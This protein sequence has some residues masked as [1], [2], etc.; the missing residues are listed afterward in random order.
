MCG[1]LG[2]RGQA[3]SFSARWPPVAPGYGKATN[4]RLTPRDTHLAAAAL[5][6]ARGL[7]LTGPVSRYGAGRT[8]CGLLIQRFHRQ[9]SDRGIGGAYVQGETHQGNLGTLIARPRVIVGWDSCV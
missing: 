6:A 1:A 9:D 2:Q 7:S 3:W 5:R 8:R 4:H